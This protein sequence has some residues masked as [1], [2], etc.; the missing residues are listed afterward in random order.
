[1]IRKNLFFTLSF[2]PF[3]LLIPFLSNVSL[4]LLKD[5]PLDWKGWVMILVFIITLFALIREVR[6]PDVT[7]MLSTGILMILG[8]LSPEEFVGGFANE[9]IVIIGMLC[10]IVRAIEVNGIIEIIAKKVLSKSKRFVVQMLSMMIPVGA[11]SAFTNNTPVTLLMT[12]VV[13]RW[14]LG[15]NE[16]PSKFLIPLSYATILGGVC[17]LVG[18]STNIIVDGLLSNTAPEMS[19]KFFELALVGIPCAFAGFIYLIFA[20]KY[21]LPSRLDPV[22]LLAEQTREFTIEFLVQ[23][24][25]PLIDKKI[26]EIS[27]LEFPVESLIQIQRGN[28]LIDSPAR[29]FVIRQGD[30]L[31]CTGDINQIAKLHAVPGLQSEAD[32]QFKLD[33]TSSHFS[34]VV[35]STSSLLV[36][37]TLKKIDFRRNF[38]AS[39]LAVYREGK[40]V[41]GS[42]GDIVIHAGD[43]LMLLSSEAWN[44]DTQFT[45]DFYFINNN[46]KLLVFQPMRAFLVLLALVGMVTAAILDV[47]LSVATTGAAFF[48]IFTKTISMREAQKSVMWSILLLVG[49]SFAF[50]KAM[51][52]TGVA[53]YFA[54]AVLS[55]LGNNPYAIIAGIL[56]ISILGTEFL[57]NNAAALVFF[58][59]GLA[60]M[61]QAGYE[62]PESIKAVGVSVAIGCSYAFA[63]PTGYQSHMIVYGPGG[64]KFTDFLRAGIPLN[65]I[66]FI[67]ATIL[68]PLIWPLH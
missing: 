67:I 5:S 29:D 1:M 26:R 32:P 11:I 43:T 62:S 13:R 18:T 60:I 25:C 22:S 36:G 63:I 66:V 34:E 53:S 40:R 59:I 56:F 52:N 9:I 4:T 19:L 8:I 24:D 65:V 16:S 57:S 44:P 27:A 39:V 31:V 6:P 7:M 3:L 64:Y 46:E 30:H 12:P 61:K 2:I 58:P 28:T 15:N 23:Q 41:P 14:A 51:V 48:L 50:G 20:G 38:G 68:I 54:N 10:I 35:V 42:V 17:T 21:I 47:P 33:L 37:K 45:K 49:F 55:F